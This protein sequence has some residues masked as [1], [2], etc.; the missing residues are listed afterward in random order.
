MSYKLAQ[1]KKLQ[2]NTVKM[3]GSDG[4]PTH[5]CENKTVY[6]GYTCSATLLMIWLKGGLLQL[7]IE[8]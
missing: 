6:V 8:I 1:V 7:Q 2:L 3:N 5:V 4:W